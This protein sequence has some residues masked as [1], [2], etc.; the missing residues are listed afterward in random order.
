MVQ[1]R[2]WYLPSGRWG[3]FFFFPL[4]V[5]ISVLNITLITLIWNIYVKLNL[6]IKIITG[7][8]F[9]KGMGTVSL[10]G[11]LNTFRDNIFILTTHTFTRSPPALMVMRMPRI[12]RSIYGDNG[13]GRHSHCGWCETGNSHAQNSHLS[14]FIIVLCMYAHHFCSPV[15]P[16]LVGIAY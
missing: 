13:N 8:Q 11:H 6:I 7:T 16:L 5:S 15:I 2:D 9:L 12:L 1:S 4:N 14:V 3:S 10:I